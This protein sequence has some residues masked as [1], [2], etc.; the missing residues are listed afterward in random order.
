MASS[1]NDTETSMADIRL[2]QL[3]LTHITTATR[4]C[5]TVIIVLL[6]TLTW[7]CILVCLIDQI[8]RSVSLNGREYTSLSKHADPNQLLH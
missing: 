8:F 2:I 5:V 1:Y 4:S 6:N 7:A 3:E